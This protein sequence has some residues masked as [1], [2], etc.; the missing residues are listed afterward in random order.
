[1]LVLARRLGEILHI[2]TPQGVVKVVVMGI[3]EGSVVKFGLHADKEIKIMREEQK[4][5]PSI[6]S[7]SR[8]KEYNK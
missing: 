4:D 6:F 7:A 5:S 8:D 3:D 2:Q 1:M